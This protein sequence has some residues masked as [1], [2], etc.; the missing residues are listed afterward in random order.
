VGKAMSEPE[1]LCADGLFTVAQA[2]QFLGLSKTMLYQL[3]ERG[4]LPYVRIG[5]SRRIPKRV[6]VQLAAAHLVGG[7]GTA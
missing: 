7:G 3:M 1:Q 2:T 5:R 6:L 4:R